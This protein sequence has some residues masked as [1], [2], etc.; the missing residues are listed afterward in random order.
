MSYEEANQLKYL[1]DQGKPYDTAFHH[2]GV[3]NFIQLYIIYQFV[4]QSFLIV[5]YIQALLILSLILNRNH[6]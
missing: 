1:I 6:P 5:L 4:F 2:Y 3:S